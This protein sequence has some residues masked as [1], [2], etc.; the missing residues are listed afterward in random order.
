MSKSA[1]YA[2]EKSSVLQ[3]FD[4]SLGNCQ[5]ENISPLFFDPVKLVKRNVTGP[6]GFICKPLALRMH[7][8]GLEAPIYSS[9][10]CVF[11]LRGLSEVTLI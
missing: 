5:A 2:F 6:D 10:D 9:A 3:D 4:G 1:R 11:P 8:D 7:P